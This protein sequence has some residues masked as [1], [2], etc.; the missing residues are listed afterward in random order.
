MINT[1]ECIE[2]MHCLRNSYKTYLL[3][4]HYILMYLTTIYNVISLLKQN[5]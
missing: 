5:N 4:N 1:T 3:V 2:K